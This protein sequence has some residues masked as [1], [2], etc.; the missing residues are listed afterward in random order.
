[1]NSLYQSLHPDRSCSNPVPWECIKLC[2]FCRIF[3]ASHRNFMLIPVSG[4]AGLDFSIMKEILLLLHGQEVGRTF[5]LCLFFPNF[6][7]SHSRA[8]AL[9]FPCPSALG[10]S[11]EESFPVGHKTVQDGL[12]SLFS[13]T[14]LTLSP[15]APSQCADNIGAAES[16][17]LE[18]SLDTGGGFHT[19]LGQEIG[20]SQGQKCTRT[21]D[22]ETVSD[23]CESQLAWWR[24]HL[25][26]V[27]LGSG[28]FMD[29]CK[30]LNLKFRGI[31]K[32]FRNSETQRNC[33]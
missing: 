33:S 15:M 10:V 28:I 18:S 20:K 24:T 3:W 16:C 22:D 14:V 19:A 11:D 2:L 31:L 21:E 8:R 4:D 30:G 6:Y 17:L 29:I 32:F 7:S 27:R 26:W 12:I 25:G 9:A 13:Q 23:C 5:L 1:M